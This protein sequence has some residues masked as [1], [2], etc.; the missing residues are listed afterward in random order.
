MRKKDLIREICGEKQIKRNQLS[1]EDILSEILIKDKIVD[2]SNEGIIDNIKGGI[3]KIKEKIKKYK[4]E[5]KEKDIANAWKSEKVLEAF[6]ELLKGLDINGKPVNNTVVLKPEYCHL[7]SIDDKCDKIYSGIKDLIDLSENNRLMNGGELFITTRFNKIDTIVQKNINDDHLDAEDLKL[8]Y[9]K[10]NKEK[11]LDVDNFINDCKTKLYPL[12]HNDK[13]LSTT[14]NDVKT[15]FS[16]NNKYLGNVNIVNMIHSKDNVY[17]DTSFDICE[18]NTFY[19]NL[20]R[21]KNIKQITEIKSLTINEIQE[22]IKLCIEGIK[23]YRKGLDYESSALSHL[24]DDEISNIFFMLEDKL[25]RASENKN[26]GGHTIINIYSSMLAYL[27]GSEGYRTS[28]EEISY[29]LF[30][31]IKTTYLYL[32]A[33]IRNLK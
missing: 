8:I 14:V 10:I 13:N 2:Y 7:L 25:S 5:K 1:L 23:V 12:A 24:N 19:L 26:I 32:N 18:W 31:V 20:N 4:Q 21:N 28:Y 30:R 15:I 11:L 3:N 33:C 6:E 29:H 22:L 17:V 27:N 16:S 9:D